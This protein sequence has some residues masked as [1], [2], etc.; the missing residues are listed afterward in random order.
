MCCCEQTSAHSPC[1]Q[2]SGD[3]QRMNLGGG[4][5]QTDMNG[6][7]EQDAYHLCICSHGGQL[8]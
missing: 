1:A 7:V 3:D 4:L 5:A 2:S 8:F 6:A